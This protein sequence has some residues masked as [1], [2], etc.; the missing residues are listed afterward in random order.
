MPPGPTELITAVN[1]P[2]RRRILRVY[3][4]GAVRDASVTEVARA[5]GERAAKVAYHLKT[6]VRCDVLRPVA[7]RGG[8]GSGAGSE[9]LYAWALPG[10]GQW[11]RLVIDV[12]AQSDPAG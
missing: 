12:W 6:L 3:L 1:H 5:T 7:A 2:L 10:E 4:D 11:L 8:E 9:P